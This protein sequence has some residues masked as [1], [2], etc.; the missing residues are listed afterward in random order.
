MWKKLLPPSSNSPTKIRC[1]IHGMIILPPIITY[2]SNTIEFNKLRLISQLG[3]AQLKY[4]SA[5]HSRASHSFGVAHLAGKIGKKLECTEKEI[6]LLQVAGLLHDIGHK[7]FSHLYEEAFD[8]N[9]E[10]E[11]VIIAEK[12]LKDVMQEDEITLVKDM[13]LGNERKERGFLTQIVHCEGFDV[14][15]IDYIMRDNYF[16]LGKKLDFSYLIECYRVTEG[17]IS[18]LPKAALQIS[19]LWIE[20]SLLFQMVYLEKH[21]RSSAHHLVEKM[22]TMKQDDVI[23]ERSILTPQFIQELN[24]IESKIDVEFILQ[25][26]KSLKKKSKIWFEVENKLI[27]LPNNP[28]TLQSF[29]QKQVLCKIEK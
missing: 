28:L 3:V 25:G 4:P 14:D 6:Q 20:R 18:F 2:L 16:A 7:P 21:V 5:T 10:K 11:G 17:R 27:S 1:P 15:E 9:H 29:Y 8:Y 22:K 19:E 13:I 24:T 26:L 12:L 23:H